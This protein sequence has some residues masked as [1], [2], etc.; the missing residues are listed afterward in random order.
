[1]R[2]KI[3]PIILCGGSG[4][5]LLPFLKY[6][7]PKQF[8]NILTGVNNLLQN[9][10]MRFSDGCTFHRPI[11]VGGFAYRDNIIKSLHDIR[12]SANAIIFEREGKNTGPAI[13]SAAAYL[14]ESGVHEQT[15]L[16]TVPID[17]YIGSTRRF[18]QKIRDVINFMSHHAMQDKILTLS[19]HKNSFETNYGHL[20]VGRKITP[21]VFEVINFVEK[22]EFEMM[23]Q[24]VLWNSGIYCMSLRTCRDL[25]E[26]NAPYIWHYS[27]RSMTQGCQRQSYGEL[28]SNEIV[29]NETYFMKNSKLSFDQV[30]TMPYRNGSIVC[31]DIGTEW[32][33][34][35]IWSGIKR[36]SSGVNS[37][38]LI[39]SDLFAEKL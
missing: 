2:V 28:I 17:H 33:D 5:R 31:T 21:S 16:L 27:H 23:S 19:V 20:Q 18:V 8:L 30:L 32:E 15:L 39:N 7:S 4:Q 26:K 12:R 14:R 11:V 29:L 24:S 9:T 34:I 36:L 3:I 10:V 37:K 1:M 25:F 35:G 13:A 6:N 22:P 38:K